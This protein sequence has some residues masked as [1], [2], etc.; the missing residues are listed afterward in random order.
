MDGF[1]H[2]YREAGEGEPLLLLHG[3]GEDS[4]YFSHQLAEFASC[5]HVYAL[6]TRGHGRS[7]RGTAPFTLRQFAED[8]R[9]FLDRMGMERAHILGFS[10]GANIAMAFALAHPERVGKLVLNGGNLDPGG[11]KASFQLLIEGE[12]RLLR[13]FAGL[14]PRLRRRTE[15]LGLMVNEPNLTPEDLAGITAPTLVIAGD[16]DLI[17]DAHTRT[18][19]AHLPRGELAILPGG[20]TVAQTCYQTF[21]RRVLDFLTGHPG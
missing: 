14:S 3:N 10:D 16:R 12:Y 17:R 8:L 9:G 13:P 15:L 7:P 5:Y 1:R 20:H 21:N 4:T 19:A 6:D 11:V 18:I 2:F